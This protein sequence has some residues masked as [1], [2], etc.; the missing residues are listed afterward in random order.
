MLKKLVSLV[1]SVSCV[2]A[3]TG[4][5]A[6]TYTGTV[7]E[8][9]G[10]KIKV[11]SYVSAEAG[12]VL[13]Y[14]AYDRDVTNLDNLNSANTVYIDQKTA[15]TTGDT[16]FSY[17]TASTHVNAIVK[18][19]GKKTVSTDIA[20]GKAEGI[21][22]SQQISVS[23][24]GGDAVLGAIPAVDDELTSMVPVT[25][26]DLDGQK[27]TGVKV[28]GEDETN[29]YQNGNVIY[30]AS[31]Y[32]QN[33]A[34]VTIEVASAAVEATGVDVI[35]GGIV[36]DVEEEAVAAIGKVDAN[37]AEQGFLFATSLEG[38]AG[39]TGLYSAGGNAFPALGSGTDGLFAVKLT[40]FRVGFPEFEEATGL[41][42]RA[43]VIVNGVYNY[44]DEY[45]K[46]NFEE[47]PVG[48]GVE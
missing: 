37:A 1:V 46:I 22:P 26:T 47:V 7:S 8:Y 5:S 36:K 18:V 28:N 6:A 39:N 14:L 23:L 33:V 24:N 9:A 11:T 3:A 40:D 12:D 13:T 29:Y 41:Y 45:V 15:A 2:L 44:S 30:L 25:V 21:S 10:D 43:Y 16:T 42:A 32:F 31:T 19:G 34:L 17:T 35:A 48:G 4:V 38:V 27:V 20:D